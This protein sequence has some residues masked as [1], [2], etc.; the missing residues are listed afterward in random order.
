MNFCEICEHPFPSPMLSEGV[1]YTCWRCHAAD[2]EDEPMIARWAD[3]H[4]K[5]ARGPL[6]LPEHDPP[7]APLVPR[8]EVLR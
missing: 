6:A 7:L 2:M 3:Y 4:A 1:C 5:Q 8:L